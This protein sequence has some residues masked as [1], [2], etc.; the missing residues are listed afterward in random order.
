MAYHTKVIKWGNS[1]AI[2]LPKAL[3]EDLMLKIG[4]HLNIKLTSDH[5][6]IISRDERYVSKEEVRDE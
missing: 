6:L 3:Q 2:S 1:Q 5:K 4:D